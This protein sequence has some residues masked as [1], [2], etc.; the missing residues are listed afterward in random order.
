MLRAKLNPDGVLNPP[1]GAA[2][3]MA[4]LGR[5]RRNKLRLVD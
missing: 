5:L 3:L 1:F 2:L 4:S